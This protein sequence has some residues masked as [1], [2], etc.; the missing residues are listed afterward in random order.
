MKQKLTKLV[1]DDPWLEPYAEIISGRI[2]EADKKE[3]ELTGNQSLSDFATGYLF[4]EIGRASC[5][6]R[7]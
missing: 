7:V 5:R 3:T 6:E 1:K 4:F 2:A